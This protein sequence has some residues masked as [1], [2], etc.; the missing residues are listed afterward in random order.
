MTGCCGVR[1]TELQRPHCDHCREALAT[2]ECERCNQRFC[3]DCELVIHHRLEKL[4]MK[5]EESK[6]DGRPHQEFL[7][8]INACL[9]CGQKMMEFLCVDCNAFQCGSCC[10]GKH[11][12]ME[13]NSGHMYFC[14]EGSSPGL[15]KYAT[16]NVMFVR[17]VKQ[18]KQLLQ[19]AVV[20]A[21]T[22]ASSI[23]TGAS[24]QETIA[25]EDT[26]PVNVKMEQAAMSTKAT[27]AALG[28]LSINAD[29]KTLEPISQPPASR[30]KPSNRASASSLIDLTL[31]D[32]SDSSNASA[33]TPTPSQP[34]IKE[35]PRVK[36][37]RAW[38]DAMSTETEQP[39]FDV[40][41]MMEKTMGEDEDPILRSLIAE[42]NKV[43]L[44]I[45]KLD[46]E[47]EEVRTKTKELTSAKPINMAEVNKARVAAKKLRDD[48]AAAEE[49]RNGA[50]ANLVMYMK[51]E[52]EEL[53][54]F[55][56]TCVVDIPTAQDAI[57]RKCATIEANIRERLEHIQKIQRDLEDLLRMKKDAFAEVTRL[58]AEI[59][60]CEEEVRQLDK[61]RLGEFLNLCKYSR[62]ITEA[63]RAMV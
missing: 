34:R 56:A 37:E 29:E 11:L 33:R 12:Q 6:G 2:W 40:D 25:E 5:H 38:L 55:L 63:V 19:D 16:W 7:R 3:Q 62:S 26:L 35:E 14:L 28:N 21:A 32:E 49:S 9:V 47:A 52:P 31:D 46:Q 36:D 45:Y 42:Y 15:L 41:T 59:V 22:A 17:S 18:C 53:Q 43:G 23:A 50:V 54:A 51:P 39:V 1:L 13:E 44:E 4:A 58:G 48:K 20:D 24:S 57:H 60:G 30:A 27:T 8:S 61:A 10:A